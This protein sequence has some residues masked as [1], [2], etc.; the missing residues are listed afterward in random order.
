MTVHQLAPVF[1]KN[2]PRMDAFLTVYFRALLVWALVE[3]K[4][5]RGM[6]RERLKSLSLYPWNATVR[7]QLPS[8]PCDSSARPSATRCSTPVPLFRPWSPCS[9]A[10]A[11][12]T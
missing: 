10:S 9:P 12:S 2:P 11:A 4:R 7:D 3:R 5:R 1:V 6:K 8:S